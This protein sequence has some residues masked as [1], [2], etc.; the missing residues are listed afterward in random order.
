MNVK[1]GEAAM[2][3]HH[4][5]WEKCIQRVGGGATKP[6]DIR[7][8][9]EIDCN[10]ILN[11]NAYRRLKHKTQ[12]FFATQNDHICTRIEHVSHVNSISYTI[13][14]YLGLNTELTTAISLAHDLGH[15]PFGHRGEVFLKEIVKRE[16][17][18]DFWHEK[19][20]L[21]FVDNIETLPDSK[22]QERNL[23]LTYAVRDGI[24][25]HCGE[26][27]ENG[28][29]PRRDW[30][31]LSQI[32]APSEYLPYT[33]EGCVVKIADKIAFLGRDIEDAL[34]LDILSQKQLDHLKKILGVNFKDINNTNIISRLV[35]D[36]CQQSVPQHGL[37][38]SPEYFDLIK[39]L[40]DFN[41]ANIYAHKRI[42]AYMEYAKLALESIYGIL[43]EFYDE[44]KEITLKN[45][46][47]AQRQYP[48]LCKTFL[49]WLAK[50]S[51][52][53]LADPQSKYKNRII[54]RIG[55]DKDYKWACID[56]IAGMTDNFVISIFN[57]LI[58]FR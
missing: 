10:R 19:N 6:G 20:S 46:S 42:L 53:K 50:Y 40:R 47:R 51:D 55:N 22:G 17:G 1:F 35:N 3:P 12:V 29:K 57:E 49:G 13:A 45:I 33:W 14:K 54:Y 24:V 30:L 21:F 11:C 39:N 58:S 18:D 37:L 7:S 27:D 15:A 23:N 32:G 4:P 28:L 34:S 56:F 43:A 41:Y 44:N 25:M 52:A 31:D 9:F 16:I 5:H 48:L 26:V 36:L 38:F 8:E 2:T